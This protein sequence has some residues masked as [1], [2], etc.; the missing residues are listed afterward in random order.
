MEKQQ[1]NPKTEHNQVQLS[2]EIQQKI[3]IF[4]MRV[5]NIN[6]GFNDLLTSATDAIKSLIEENQRLRE[7]QKSE[8]N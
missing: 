5:A 8:K 6:L 7:A 4:N 2:S 1:L 3:Q